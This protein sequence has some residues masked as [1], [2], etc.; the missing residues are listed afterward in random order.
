MRFIA[1]VITT[2]VVIVAVAGFVFATG[3]FNVGATAPPDIIDKLA[4]WALDESLERRARDITD[5]V[6][7]DA[8][9]LARGMS[10]YRGNCLPCRGPAGVDAVEAQD[11]MNRTP[12]GMGSP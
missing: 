12:R 1:G 2:L 9:A 8:G 11:G 7:K 3:R 4:P 6:A 10:H 5:P